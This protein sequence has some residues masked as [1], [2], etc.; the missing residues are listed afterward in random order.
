MRYIECGHQRH[1]WVGTP[2]A[3]V[4]VRR[5]KNPPTVCRDWGPVVPRA[6]VGA[7]LEPGSDP[8]ADRLEK[9]AGGQVAV[10]THPH[11]GGVP[12]NQPTLSG[13]NQQLGGP[14]CPKH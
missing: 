7:A 1:A 9:T 14:T 11:F 12:S 10:C 2:R 3:T 5:E 6:P 4:P 8:L 13:I